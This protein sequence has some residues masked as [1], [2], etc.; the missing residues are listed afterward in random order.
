MSLFTKIYDRAMLP[1][2]KRYIKRIRKT[3]LRYAH[4]TVL[5][6]GVGT[7]ANFPFYPKG[8]NVIGIEP[9]EEMLRQ[10]RAKL[11]STKAPV[12]LLLGQAESLPFA[13]ESFDTVLATLVLCSVHNL[14]KSLKELN[15]V[16]KPNG[17]I[18]VFE[19]I[20]L[21]DP[22]WVGFF[23]DVFTPSWAYICDGCHL[24][25]DT[26][27]EAQ[28]YFE[29]ENISEHFKRLFITAVGKRRY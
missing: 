5:E 13:D 14:D 9:N 1:L 16:L 24:N 8:V 2:E 10:A 17:T 11:D 4:G 7:G 19:H 3:I 25:R 20:R 6:I 26:I 29:F 23:Q 22:R 21:D 18:I 28:K 27:K 15:R 12:E